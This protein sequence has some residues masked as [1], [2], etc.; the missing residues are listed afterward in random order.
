MSA[1]EPPGPGRARLHTRLSAPLAE[2]L[3]LEAAGG[4][5]LAAA[6]VVALVWANSPWQDS[7]T[8]LWNTDLSITLGSHSLDLTLQQ[9]INDGLMAVFF[10]VVGLEIKRELVTGELREPRRATLPAI[11]AL[12]GMVVPA[13]IYLAINAGGPGAHGWGIP[14]ATDIAMAVGVVSLLGARVAPSLKIFLLALAIVDDLGAIVVI[15]VFY[16]DNI[17]LD[18]LGAALLVLVAVYVLGRLGVRFLPV[19][20][21]LGGLAWL[22]VHEA[23][24][25]A[26]LAGVI[27]GL[28]T[29]TSPVRQ[30]EDVR[31]EDLLDISTPEAA[32]QT[33]RTAREAVSPAA[34]LEYALHPWSSFVIV[35]LFALANAG[36]P[37]STAALADAASSRIT[38]GVVAGLV[39][40][41]LVGITAFSWLGVRLRIGALPEGATWRAM[42]GIAAVAG[43][44]FTVAI[45]VSG[46]AFEDADLQDQA[47]VGILVASVVA[48][49]LGTLLLARRARR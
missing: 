20:V 29:P 8:T 7:Y 9:W 42:A 30:R 47:K 34:W 49:A 22:L 37:L 14:T 46:L 13:L 45:F 43:I 40:G 44:G 48:G 27:L 4:I 21:V 25:H 39:A 41:K 23:G 19:Y 31:D 18:S 1:N 36:I 38:Y 11:A 6:T 28:M 2:F 24:V 3:H 10:F 17:H 16:S 26:T 15:A 5:V 33:A 12:G 32:R 35:P